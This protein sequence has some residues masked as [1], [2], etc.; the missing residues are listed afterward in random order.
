MDELRGAVLLQVG[1]VAAVRASGGPADLQA[2]VPNSHST[3]F[4]LASVSKQFTAAAVMLLADR[5]SLTVADPVIRWLDA[6]LAPWRDITIGHLLTH[7]SG[8]GHWDDMP[9]IDICAAMEPTS[10]LEVIKSQPLVAKPG[11]RWYYSSLGYFLLA[12]IVQRAADRRYAE[13]LSDEIFTPLGMTATFAGNGVGEPQL[14]VGYADGKP[15]TS[16][17]LDRTN[18]GAGDVWSTT[19]D[20]AL[21][22]VAVSQRRLLSSASWDASLTSHAPIDDPVAGGGPVRFEGYGYGWMTGAVPA[23]GVAVYAHMGGNAGFRT[24]NLVMPDR[25]TCLVILSN[26]ES[27]DMEGLAAEVLAASLA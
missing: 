23:S 27:T 26:D 9:E 5:G 2:G 17:E 6:C 3:R 4:Q 22:D 18:M 12:H 1:D 19:E 7:T 10:Q 11:E 16:Y 25:D 14:A 13:F 20:M 15:T 24:L 21:W 8:I